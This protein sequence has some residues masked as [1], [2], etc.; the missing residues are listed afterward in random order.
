[1]LQGNAIQRF[2]LSI[3]RNDF[4]LAANR[5]GFIGIRV[6]P[7]AT[8]AKPSSKFSRLT[9]ASLLAPVESLVRAPRTGYKKDEFGWTTDSYNT[10]EHGLESDI[11][12]SE[13][14]LYG[15]FLPIEQISAARVLDRILT[16]HE[17]LV[18]NLTFAPTLYTGNQKIT[19][20]GTAQFNNVTT[21]TPVDVIYQ[22][23]AQHHQF[24]LDANTLIIPELA[25]WYLKR[26]EQ[27]F[28]RIKYSG[29]DNPKQVTINV[30][31]EMFELDNI[32]VAKGYKNTTPQG[33]AAPAFARL[34]DPTMMMVCRI[35]DPSEALTESKPCL[36]RTVMYAEQNAQIP[37]IGDG[38]MSPAVIMEE[39]REERR[40]GGVIRGRWNYDLK[41][42]S[43]PMADGTHFRTGVLITN[44]VTTGEF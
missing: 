26:S 29:Q 43:D 44:V 17:Q 32:L 18:A 16:E 31:K 30:L 27:I 1:M 28:S 40:R 19:L 24:G 11:D 33:T 20:T 5:E 38:N 35:A 21:S 13:L 8:V 23:K 22:A 4:D 6:M 10:V 14:E 2:D 42:F 39:Y 41:S 12:D 25:L 37:G 36:G 34:W 3:R 9:I 7:P 15:D